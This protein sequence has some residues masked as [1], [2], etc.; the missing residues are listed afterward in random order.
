MPWLQ[1]FKQ[2]TGYWW[3]TE[4]LKKLK[5]A[6]VSTL[7]SNRVSQEWNCGRTVCQFWALRL[8]YAFVMTAGVE[9]SVVNITKSRGEKV[10]QLDGL[11]HNIPWEIHQEDSSLWSKELFMNLVLHTRWTQKSRFILISSPTNGLFSEPP[12]DYRWRWCSKCWEMLSC[13]GRNS[14]ILSYFNI[15]KPNLVVKGIF[16]CFN[17]CVKFACI[18]EIST[19][20]R[21]QRGLL[22]CVHPV[23]VI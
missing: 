10:P 5:K 19:K 13:L 21:G 6:Q 4:K 3:K 23:H 8:L 1:R 2:I 20:S 9:R 18:S 7:Q 11:V 14:I 15:F 16:S 17:S 22:F 12:T